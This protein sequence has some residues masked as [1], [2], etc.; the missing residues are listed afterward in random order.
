VILSKADGSIVREL[1][2]VEAPFVPARPDQNGIEEGWVYEGSR[3]TIV[4]GRAYQ[5]I[6]NEVQ[7]RDADTGE[8]LW[9]RRYTDRAHARPA[10][11][12]AI[13]TSAIVFGTRD[14][15]VYGLD[16]D[17]GL[18][19]FA[20][21]VGQPIAAQPIV[22]G[23]WVYAATTRGGL[24]AF[25][26]GD[27]TVGGWHMWGGNSKHNG[28]ADE[29]VPAEDEERPSEGVLELATD[30][31]TGELAGFP[32]ESTSVRARVNGFAARVEVEQTFENPYD[33]AVEAV[34]LFPLPEDSAVDEMELRTGDRVVRANI[35]R[36]EQARAE[37][38]AARD[39]GVLASLL[40][41]ERPNLFRQSIANIAPGHRVSV[42][43]RY[44]HVL[45]YEEGSYRFV[46]PM[47]AGPRYTP[48][49]TD[50]AP[51]AVQS[52]TLG[53]RR[54]RVRVEIEAEL[55][56]T[57]AEI[58]SPTHELAIDRPT[59]TSASV[60]LREDARPD[61]DLDVRFAVAGDEPE[62][63]VLASSPE[64]DE[65][66]FVTLL[67]HP[68]LAVPDAEIAPREIVFLVDTSSSMRGRPI[69][70]AK[71]AMKRAL[72][73]LRPSDTFRVLR[74]SDMVGELAEGPLEASRE[75]VARAR[76][77][78]DELEALGATEMKRGIRAALEAPVDPA[79]MRIVLLLT[80][81]YIGNETEI[82][83]EVHDR[84][85]GARLFA[86]GVGGAVNRYLLSRLAEHG[87]GD[88]QVVT[89]DE[90]PEEAADRFHDLIGSPFLTDV[91]IDWGSLA[92]RDVYPRRVPD[93]FADR[94]LVVHG[95]YPSGGSGSIVV[96][97][98]IAGRAFE[99]T[100]SVTLP[101]SS[102]PNPAIASI[103]ARTR[104][105]D[106]T[107]AMTLAP[108]DSLREEVVA[109]GLRHHLL[110]EWT[111]FV[112]ID[113]S[114]EAASESA[115]VRVNQAT[116]AA[117][118]PSGFAGGGFGSVAVGYGSGGGDTIGYGALGTLGNAS[119][120][121]NGPA[122]VSPPV[123]VVPRVQTAEATV[124]GSLSTDVIRRVVRTAFNNFRACYERALARNPNLHGRI[125]LHLVIG[126]DGAVDTATAG[127]DSLGDAEVA[128]C[129][130]GVARRLS[131]P[132]VEGGGVVVV[133]YPLVFT[134]ED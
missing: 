34:Y 53:E 9:R 110:T 95:R 72:E 102:A 45:P 127:E 58:T 14:G 41:Q 12:P 118:Q 20:Y 87:R 21:D 89:L 68:R 130:A 107:T 120:S 92:V 122:P 121:W 76:R 88:V 116:I 105:A 82:F 33:R 51:A 61:R 30:P 66:G 32:L 80:D 90:S 11:P 44:T 125:G 117:A 103:W 131:F 85:G 84:L 70:L 22:A 50:D 28:L 119:G 18:T 37:Y 3:P 112:A 77:Y 67:V 79:R 101:A 109:L 106:L 104:I 8:L 46:F 98:R 108:S 2:A 100:V 16:I 38:R 73:G 78:V 86:F 126:P 75:N 133:H 52:S 27:R 6:G 132:A 123:T 111:A 13:A 63:S 91:S 40:E 19:T 31:R 39:R 10:S 83:R 60:R 4:D 49:E 99:K 1:D 7:A 25:E 5:T 26:I 42:V 59:A 47:V 29:V 62:V 128:A 69:G 115:P 74:F 96:R 64:P 17:T 43:L 55:G 129:V 97:G 71:A 15:I 35:R 36:R 93:L 54:D 56:G 113:A 124:R 23:G 24:V 114:S 81:G 57:L 48:A 94:P 65:A 134:T